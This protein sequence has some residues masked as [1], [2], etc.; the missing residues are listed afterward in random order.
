MI[1]LLGRRLRHAI[2]GRRRKSG[3]AAIDLGQ[4]SGQE[5]AQAQAQARFPASGEEGPEDAVDVIPLHLAPG[6]TL[7]GSPV[8]F[9]RGSNEKGRGRPTWS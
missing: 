9:R 6:Q 5:E 2:C 1:I 8:P 3:L 4:L 7:Y